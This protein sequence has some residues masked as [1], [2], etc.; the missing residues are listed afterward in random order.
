MSEEALAK[1]VMPEGY[2]MSEI[3]SDVAKIKRAEAADRERDRKIEAEFSGHRGLKDGRNFLWNVF[4][5]QSKSS[6]EKYRSN[7]DLAFP[8]SPG[9]GL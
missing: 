1:A 7:F 8:D 6:R 9:A 3:K 2:T 4:R 5:F